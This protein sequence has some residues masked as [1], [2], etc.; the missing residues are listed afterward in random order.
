[1]KKLIM[2]AV[3]AM[4]ALNVTAEDKKEAPKKG[5][6]A[7]ILKALDLTKEQAAKLKEI[8]AEFG[9]KLKGLSKEDRRT[10]GRELFKARQEAIAKIL[11][12][13]QLAKLKEMQ[14]KRRG[15]GKGK[16]KPEAK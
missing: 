9:A 1:M 3:A 5:G 8:N 7:N 11:N 15:P 16:K 13:K 2:I 6:R 10:K 12:E 14:A 4:L